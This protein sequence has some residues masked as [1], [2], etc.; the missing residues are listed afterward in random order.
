MERPGQFTKDGTY[1]EYCVTSAT[2]CIPLDAN[3]SFEQGANG[4]VNPLTAIGLL[5]KCKTYK[6]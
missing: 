2:N 3:V 1:A 5:E 6:A 4:V